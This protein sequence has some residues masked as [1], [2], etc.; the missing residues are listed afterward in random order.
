MICFNCWKRG[1]ISRNCHGTPIESVY[2]QEELR[3]SKGAALTPTWKSIL[4][5]HGIEPLIPEAS[6]SA[7]SP[8]VHRSSR[9]RKS[10]VHTGKLD[11]TPPEVAHRKELKEELKQ[12]TKGNPKEYLNEKGHRNKISSED[13][14]AFPYSPSRIKEAEHTDTQ[15]NHPL[16]TISNTNVDCTLVK[17]P[18]KPGFA[19]RKDSKLGLTVH[20]Y[21]PL[22]SKQDALVIQSNSS[23]FT[24]E[25]ARYK[26][27]NGG[28]R[29]RKQK[30]Q[31][32]IARLPRE[33]LLEIF[34]LSTSGKVRQVSTENEEQN[35]VYNEETSLRNKNLCLDPLRK[36]NTLWRLLCQA[37]LY[38]T[39]PI[40]SVRS[41]E[42]FSRTVVAHGDLS[43]LVR[44]LKIDIP[45]TTVDGWTP[46]DVV[47]TTEEEKTVA[48]SSAKCLS[49]I[50]AACPNLINLIARF[51]GSFQTLFFLDRTYRT[52]NRL[53][54]D[55]N[56]SRKLDVKGLWKA[57]RHFPNLQVL[58]LEA[59]Q[60]PITESRSLAIVAGD[61]LPKLLPLTSLGFKNFPF[62]H[63]AFLH[64]ILP[65][66][67]EL[68]TLHIEKCSGISSKGI[69][70]P[71]TPPNSNYPG[72]STH[73]S[74]GLARALDGLNKTKIQ[75]FTYK[76]WKPHGG[77]SDMEGETSNSHH[78]CEIIP[79]K[80]SQSL[81]NLHISS[82]YICEKLVEGI[83]WETLESI[84]ISGV[85]FR[86]CKPTTTETSL[87]QAIA[88][89]NM[90]QL[91]Q[92]PIIYFGK[93]HT[94]STLW[95]AF[96]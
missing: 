16:E 49:M 15:A 82:N 7:T 77:K 67:P 27:V 32:A 44:E 10:T 70:F 84:D 60:E 51:A 69:V 41:L 1:H 72:T 12:E 36:V 14:A 94:T 23:P 6:V 28:P 81:I 20:P 19:F 25:N 63:D 38:R 74:I 21:K 88:D 57:T 53:Y 85:A 13:G 26:P 86:G 34:K 33:L 35:M 55:D 65:R 64:S 29:A 58:Q 79:A 31:P 46:S 80:L 56:L 2:C 50:I 8:N 59:G 30:G 61:L 42:Q 11:D 78:L 47:R 3:V 92:H 73:A 40:T 43:V 54:L 39:V 76:A 18:L 9:P 93:T 91:T 17:I 87:R 90:P 48:F 71:P 4:K 96:E 5:G 66:L 37:E 75:S 45:F 68:K 95:P 83:S 24:P 22:K 52:L 89:A 62:I